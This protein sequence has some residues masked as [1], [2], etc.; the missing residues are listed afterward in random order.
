VL[1]PLLRTYLR[2]YKR[3]LMF[4]VGLQFVATMAAL[5]LPSLNANIIDN[6]VAKGNTSYILHT[7]A[8][9]LGITVVQVACA[10]AAVYFGSRAAMA[11]GRDSRAAVFRKV[12]SFSARE[13]TTFGAPSLITRTTNDVQQVQMLV[14][15]SCTLMVSAPITCVGGI[16]MAMRENLQLSWL[17]AIAVPIL[18]IAIALIVRRMVPQ[19]RQMQTRIDTVNRVLREQITGIRV[20]RAFVREP[21]E[22]E[23]FSQANSDLT[24]TSLRVGRLMALMFPTVMIVLNVSS[25]AVLWF[26][27]HLVADGQMPVGA[28]SA[29]L[30]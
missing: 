10:I 6:G 18:V 11:F 21:V 27:G 2:P 20:V 12:G 8:I 28:L 1:I 19:F 9:M 17:I 5:F 22:R 16:I 26:G 29:F 30:N 23:R 14:L 15:L 4:V 24:G 13:M 7:G 25:V 3:E